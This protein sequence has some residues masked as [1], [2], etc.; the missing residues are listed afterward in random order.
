M[1]NHMNK[2]KTTIVVDEKVW[3]EFKK[4]ISSKYG[5]QRN[6]SLAVEEAIK[7]FN[8]VELLKSFSS[9]MGLDTNIYP[10]IRDVESRRPKLKTS[11]GKVIREMRD[12]R[13]ARIPGFQQHCEEVR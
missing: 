11:A 13:E 1:A 9:A 2:L 10:S 6:L 12:E 3:N 7:C 8:V 5:S 4:T